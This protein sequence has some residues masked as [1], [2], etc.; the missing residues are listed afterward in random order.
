MNRLLFALFALVMVLPLGQ[1]VLAADEAGFVSLF[2]GKTLNG[3]DG[4]PRLW[5]VEDGAIVGE[6]AADKPVVSNSF[7]IYTGGEF[8]DF[9]LRF[10]YRITPVNDKGFANSGVQYRSF[11]IPD[12]KNAW[13]IGGYQADFEAGDTWSGILYGEAFRGILA[14]RGEKTVVGDNHKPTVVEKIGD[15]AEIQTHIKKNDWN[16]YVITASGYHFT[17]QINGVKTIDCTD[18][19]KEK[20][21][22]SGLL[23]IQV[24]KGEPMKVQVRNIRI[25]KL[26]VK[27]A[28]ADSGGGKKKIVLVPGKPSHGWGA[29][30]HRAGCLLLADQL[31]RSGLAVEA[32]VTEGFG[33]PKD[34]SVFDGADAIVVYCDGGGGHL[35]NPHI[36]EFDKLM[37][38]G[39]G[40]VCL[41]Y[42]VETVKGEP[43]DHFLKWIGG[44]FETDWSVNPHWVANYDKLPDHQITRGVKSFKMNDEWYYHMRFAD[45]MQCVTPILTDLPPAS[46]LSRKDG[47][48]SGNPAVRKE[49]LEEKKPQHM[50]WAYE[51][52]DDYNGG[53]GFGFTGAHFHWN[54]GHDQ[55][56]KL[57]LNAICWTARMQIPEAGVPI[58]TLT[59]KDLEANQDEK[60]PDNWKTDTMQKQ[61][62][63]WNG[64]QTVLADEPEAGVKKGAD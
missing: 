15:S 45:T 43:G 11:R 19:D 51:R 21:R 32:I 25:K 4:D 3:W 63:Q 2:D 28:A 6:T 29:H 17:H 40:L 18:Q 50:A 38:K 37:K 41:H 8:G 12:E 23:A 26:S 57:V 27:H 5:R 44:Y 53:R 7:L 33:Y 24:H 49:V 14:K 55:F 30:E 42:G 10:E 22:D 1:S 34:A 13:R 46:T 59:A 58:Q 9:E 60:K 52:G 61:I 35:L 39:V 48:H 20:R 47:P 31:N 56:R 16:D 64:T 62:D 36:A 54:W